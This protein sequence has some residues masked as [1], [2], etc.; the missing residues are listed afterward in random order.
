MRSATTA[1]YSTTAPVT[2]RCR[3][4]TVPHVVFFRDSCL[5]SPRPDEQEHGQAAHVLDLAEV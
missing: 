1:T 2:C 5:S 4:C 3:E